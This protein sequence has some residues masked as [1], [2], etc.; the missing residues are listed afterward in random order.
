MKRRRFLQQASSAAA[1]IGIAGMLPIELLAANRKKISPH[2][3]LGVAVI[4]CKGMGWTN[5]RRHFL[6][7]GV[8]CVALCDVDQR[9]LDERAAEVKEIQGKA[10]RLYGDYRKL[11]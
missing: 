11:L 9:V 2:E 5:M 4:G 6:V 1:G 7:D 3:K 10:P 8:E